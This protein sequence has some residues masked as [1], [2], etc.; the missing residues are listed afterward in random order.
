MPVDSIDGGQLSTPVRRVDHYHY[1]ATG[2]GRPWQVMSE[3]EGILNEVQATPS[4]WSTEVSTEEEGEDEGV[5][6]RQEIGREGGVRRYLKHQ[7]P[8]R[9]SG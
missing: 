4:P 6:R 5:D 3:G 2:P 1:A 7:A 9:E 8:V